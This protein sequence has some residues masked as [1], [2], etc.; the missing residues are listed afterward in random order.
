[1][2]FS[3][4]PSEYKRMFNCAEL[5]LQGSEL[6]TAYGNY[7]YENS[8]SIFCGVCKMSANKSGIFST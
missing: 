1:M 3:E 4:Q 2:R 5:L 8:R 7:R 6:R